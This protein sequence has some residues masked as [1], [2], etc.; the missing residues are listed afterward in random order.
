MTGS[1]FGWTGDS[2]SIVTWRYDPQVTDNLSII[3]TSIVTITS[4][5]GRDFLTTGVLPGRLIRLSEPAT[6]APL[7][8]YRVTSVT[9]DGNVTT[10]T[11]N[12][13]QLT[14][15]TTYF[16]RVGSLWSGTTSYANTNPSSTSTLTNLILGR[17]V[18]LSS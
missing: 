15:N 5:S 4:L 3:G 13:G 9:T 12:N 7:G 14:A 1:V 17:M 10:L 2:S 6:G 18:R 16:V 8:A 11:F